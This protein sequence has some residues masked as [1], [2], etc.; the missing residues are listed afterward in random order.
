MVSAMNRSPVDIRTA[1]LALPSD[2]E[3]LVFLL[4]EYARDD[5]GG[6]QPL[7]AAVK[8]CL[9][10]ELRRRAGIH[11]L[12]AWQGTR[13]VGLAICMEGFSTFACRPLLNIHDLAVLADCRGQGIARQLLA[14]VEALACRL[15]CCKL[16]LEVLEG[17][18]VAQAVYRSFGFA[19][20]ELNPETGKALFWQ[21]SCK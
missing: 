18:R 11:V 19:G 7:A 6:G 8:R 16:T 13:P 17:N 3:A 15:D 9:V 14:A 12:L 1:D 2:A 21:K 10:P 4:N 20:Y 5:M